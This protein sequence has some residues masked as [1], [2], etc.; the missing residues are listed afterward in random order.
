MDHQV[1]SFQSKKVALRF[2]STFGDLFK[3]PL[4][5]KEN[6]NQ[7]ALVRR[8]DVSLDET[9]YAESS[10]MAHLSIFPYYFDSLLVTLRSAAATM[11]GRKEIKR[12][13]KKFPKRFPII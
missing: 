3:V 5:I 13:K 8:F 10:G 11:N 1:G 2:V 6:L 7:G 9:S 12:L 4:V